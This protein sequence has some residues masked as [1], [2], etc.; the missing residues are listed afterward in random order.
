M[1]EESLRSLE[2]MYIIYL[3]YIICGSYPHSEGALPSCTHAHFFPV[4]FYCRDT[5]EVQVSLSVFVLKV[6]E[7]GH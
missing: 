5:R 7:L 2:F 3:T 6:S 1:A 4:L